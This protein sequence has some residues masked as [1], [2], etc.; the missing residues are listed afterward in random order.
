MSGNVCP[1]GAA[2]TEAF[3]CRKCADRLRVILTGLPGRIRE[4]EDT[5]Y[6]LDRVSQP[7]GGAVTRGRVRPLPYVPHVAGLLD[8]ARGL[9]TTWARDIH[10]TSREKDSA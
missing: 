10:A 2:I 1:C 9:V 4:A 5:A 3:L 6:R 8:K 7:G